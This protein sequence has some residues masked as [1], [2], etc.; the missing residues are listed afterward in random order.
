MARAR[1]R[2]T[3][4]SFSFAHSY[5]YQWFRC[6]AIA[7]GIEKCGKIQKTAKNHKHNLIDCKEVFQLFRN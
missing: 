3:R 1:N 6:D 4:W 5:A 7:I 2:N